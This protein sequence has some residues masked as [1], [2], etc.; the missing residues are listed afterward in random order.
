MET[1]LMLL[2]NFYFSL[3]QLTSRSAPTHCDAVCWERGLFLK[4]WHQRNVHVLVDGSR[5]GNRKN[6][7]N[8]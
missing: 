7:W 5:P 6:E 2:S 1:R 4:F 3:L 8:F